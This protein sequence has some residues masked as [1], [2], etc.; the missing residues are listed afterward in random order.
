MLAVPTRLL[1]LAVLAVAIERRLRTS[2][3][4]ISRD[5]MEYNDNSGIGRGH[6]GLL[7]VTSEP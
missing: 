3:L 1:P 5:M 4:V 2:A 6:P 7:G